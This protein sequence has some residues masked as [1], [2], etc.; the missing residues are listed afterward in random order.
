MASPEHHRSTA[1]ALLA[2]ATGYAPSSA[3]RLAYLAEAQVHATLALADLTAAIAAPA[4]F[5]P[6][7][8]PVE[9]KGTNYITQALAIPVEEAAKPDAEVIEAPAP[10]R[11]TRKAPTTAKEETK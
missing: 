4:R 10:K 3:P 1:E 5:S 8:E 9:Y 11:R 7:L 6:G 2:K